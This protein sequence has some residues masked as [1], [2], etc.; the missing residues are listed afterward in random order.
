MNKRGFK[1]LEILLSLAV[2]AITLLIIGLWA[3]ATVDEQQQSLLIIQQGIGSTT[4]LA[5]LL[6]HR[7]EHGTVVDLVRTRSPHLKRAVEQYITKTEG[8]QFSYVFSVDGQQVAASG[9][10]PRETSRA[11]L[12]VPTIAGNSMRV[13]LEYER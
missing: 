13:V 9:T 1:P 5:D 3:R 8:S 12:D 4:L 10:P 7:G 2:I 6:H 11:S